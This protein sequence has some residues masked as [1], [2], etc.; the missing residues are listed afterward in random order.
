MRTRLTRIAVALFASA[1]FAAAAQAQS[2]YPCVNDAPNPYRL[3]TGWAD[4]PRQWS[5]PLGVDVD[6]HDNLWAF[7]RCEEAGCAA[8]KAAPIFELSPAGKTMRNFGAGMF[9]FPH[10][11]AADKDGDVWVVDGDVKNGKGDQVFKLAPDGKVLLTLGKAGQGKASKALDTFDQPTGVAVAGNG[12][13]FVSEGHAPGFGNSR[14]VK[15]DKNG[16]FLKTFGTLG[17]GDGQLKE[18]H[19][20][21]FD[22][23][24]RLFVADRGNSRV[25]I[26]DRD[27]K[28][29]AAWKQFG[30]PSGLAV[31]NDVLYTIDSQ[32]TGK[33]GPN[34]NPGCN[35]GIRIGSVKDGK[36]TAFIP[37]PP[38]ADPNVTPP[39]G[40]TVD[41]RGVI[42]AAAQRQNDVK[43]FVRK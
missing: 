42:Y 23:Q 15:F 27:G 38:T 18:P 1:A 14:I 16:K 30:R 40:I 35:M 25:V 11:I 26:F 39:E 7:D 17:S 8:S 29:L 6:A 37:P 36:V 41:S 5:H 43:K 13:I 24:D 9:V 4:M 3:V 34:Y 32:S 12:D 19:A 33:P 21:A 28:F 10:A 2:S 22:S 20:I 31:K